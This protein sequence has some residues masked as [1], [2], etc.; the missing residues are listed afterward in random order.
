MNWWYVSC[1]YKSNFTSSVSMLNY[2]CDVLWEIYDFTLDFL[3]FLSQPRHFIA[4]SCKFRNCLFVPVNSNTCHYFPFSAFNNL[5][6]CYKN[7]KRIQ[8]AM[9]PTHHGIGWISLELLIEEKI[10]HRFNLKI[11]EMHKQ[12]MNGKFELTF[13]KNFDW[14]SALWW[15]WSFHL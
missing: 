4:P 6:K 9:N 14:F 8:K 12:G 7:T 5:A 1:V 11:V 2:C 10:R 13:L 3:E 15:T